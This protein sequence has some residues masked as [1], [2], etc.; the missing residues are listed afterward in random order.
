MRGFTT[1][2]VSSADRLSASVRSSER[3]KTMTS[4]GFRVYPDALKGGAEELAANND[5]IFLGVRTAVPSFNSDTTGSTCFRFCDDSSARCTR[6][7]NVRIQSAF[8][9]TAGT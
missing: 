2:G 1:S 8:P 4:L 7:E 9:A 3:Q 5:I 6:T